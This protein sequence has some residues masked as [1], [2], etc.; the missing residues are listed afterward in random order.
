[1]TTVF[2]DGNQM[3]LMDG[4]RIAAQAVIAHTTPGVVQIV[5]LQ[6]PMEFRRRGMGRN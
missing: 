6:V 5:E 3:R 1:M 4:K 2:Q